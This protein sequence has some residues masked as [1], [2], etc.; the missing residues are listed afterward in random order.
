MRDLFPGYYRPTEEQFQE[1][2]KSGVFI[3]D[4][5]VLL[6]LYSYPD[7]VRNVFLSVLGKISE[8]IWIPY[9]V[10]LEFHRNKFSRIK[11]GNQ[12]IQKL[13]EM[14]KSNEAEL[15]REV[16]EVE[17][18]KRN[19]GIS[20]LPSR[21][22][23][24]KE[25]HQ[26]LLEAVQAACRKL[27]S[28]SLDDP[29]GD[30]LAELLK[31][32]VGNAPENQEALDE[33]LRDANDRYEK[34]IPPGFTDVGKGPETYR[35]KGID[36]L[37]KYGDL[38]LWRQLIAHAK[39]VELK[40]VIL[41]TSEKKEDWWR[42]EGHN[43]IGPL[44]ELIHEILE[45]GGVEVFWMYSA[46]QFLT[47]AQSYLQ[48]KEV[49]KDA[50]E[51]VRDVA[52]QHDERTLESFR[53]LEASWVENASIAEQEKWLAEHRADLD[54]RYYSR[55]RNSLKHVENKNSFEGGPIEAW[56]QSRFPGGVVKPTFGFP[57]FI[58]EDVNGIAGCE[59]KKMESFSDE[60]GN[61]SF[62]GVLERAASSL[63]NGI[64]SNF[65]VVV[66]VPRENMLRPPKPL[67][68]FRRRCQAMLKIYP[69]TEIIV[70]SIIDNSFFEIICISGNGSE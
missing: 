16:N 12:R 67:E 66:T 45:F 38:V 21:V 41:V 58:I 46:D 30:G 23:A 47:Y 11:Q 20:D 15:T 55:L 1:L 68:L 10:A 29:I 48:A 42:L 57:D 59:I 32:R 44:P 39:D 37:R 63:E 36:Y 6:S 50:I 4:T 35:D 7:D 62:F 52:A 34:K 27:P 70:G 2:W 22:A 69:V 54:G 65:L 19:I 31:G 49:T 18:E 28:P 3:F 60:G 40:Q 56:L 25:A 17:L 9:Q 61:R 53:K 43:V 14:I 26:N 51:Q 64:F 8:R 33:L 13:L 5:N 24:V